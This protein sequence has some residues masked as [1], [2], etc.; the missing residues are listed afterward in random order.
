[1]EVSDAGIWLFSWLHLGIGNL[2]TMCLYQTVRLHITEDGRPCSWKY[3]S[4]LN[5]SECIWE[6]EEGNIPVLLLEDQFYRPVGKL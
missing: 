4:I 2:E 1:M 3:K 5:Y 6:L